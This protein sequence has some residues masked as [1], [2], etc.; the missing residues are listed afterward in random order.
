MSINAPSKIVLGSTSKVSLHDRFTKLSKTKPV[1][2]RAPPVRVASIKNRNLALQMATRPSV[3]AA[4]NPKAS[5][6]K[7]SLNQRLGRINQGLDSSRLRG[8]KKGP[9]KTQGP[10]QRQK[11]ILSKQRLG[12]QQK[13][14]RKQVAISR[15]GPRGGIG[16]KNRI[17]FL[18]SNNLKKKIQKPGVKASLIKKGGI[19]GKLAAK[20]AE[21][22][23]SKESLDMDLDKYMSKTKTSL[24]ND[25]DAYMAQSQ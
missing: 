9:P 15:V 17:K 25:L 14:T 3:K 5:V 10:P 20:T 2:T 18:K 7:P 16:L 21:S 19:K 8:I 1:E 13:P 22:T 4:L 6:K 23:K 24:D 11:P 12:N